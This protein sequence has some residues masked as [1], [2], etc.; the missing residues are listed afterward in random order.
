MLLN[1]SNTK[2]FVREKLAALRPGWHVTQVSGEA[3]DQIESYLRAKIVE[4]VKRHP[5]NG[6]TFKTPL[7]SAEPKPRRTKVKRGIL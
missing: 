3:L 1:R 5:S 4:M 6:K 2:K 7:Y